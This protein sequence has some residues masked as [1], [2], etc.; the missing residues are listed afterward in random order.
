MAEVT[1]V[2]PEMIKILSKKFRY[3][4]KWAHKNTWGWIDMNSTKWT[5]I[6]GSVSNSLT[7]AVDVTYRVPQK[8]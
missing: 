5:G 2:D 8:M 1:G 3:K 4:I 6:V 7:L